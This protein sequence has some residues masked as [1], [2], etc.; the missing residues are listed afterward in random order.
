M[1][2]FVKKYSDESLIDL[3]DDIEWE[4]ET[5]GIEKN[6]DGFRPSTITVTIEW[7]PE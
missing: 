4:I 7:K 2:I 6:E 5:S 1:I 3:Q